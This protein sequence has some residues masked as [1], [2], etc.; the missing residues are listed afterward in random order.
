VKGLIGRF[1]PLGTELQEV[2][3][4]GAD[5]VTIATVLGHTTLEMAARYTHPTDR[6]LRAAVE[7]LSDW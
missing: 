2:A 5:L 3:Y 1:V 4:P 7:S 6:G